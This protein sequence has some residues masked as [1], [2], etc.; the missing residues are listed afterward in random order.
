MDAGSEIEIRD[1]QREFRLTAGLNPPPNHILATKAE[2]LSPAREVEQR[3]VNRPPEF[4]PQGTT[5]RLSAGLETKIYKCFR[6]D[7]YGRFLLVGD[8]VS[9]CFYWWAG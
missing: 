8:S 4:G 6:T 1:R 7:P 5:I 9:R 2:Q 3:L